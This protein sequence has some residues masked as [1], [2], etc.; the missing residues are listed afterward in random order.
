MVETPKTGVYRVVAQSDIRLSQRPGWRKNLPFKANLSTKERHN[1]LRDENAIEASD[2]A[3]QVVPE[4]A[5][6]AAREQRGVGRA[7]VLV[8]RAKNRLR[9]GRRSAGGGGG[10]CPGGGPVRWAGPCAYRRRCRAAKV[11]ARPVTGFEIKKGDDVLPHTW[12]EVLSDD[13]WE[14]YD[15]ENGYRR[16]MPDYFVPVA[17]TASCGDLD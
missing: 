10:A 15:P 3:V 12:V 2:P 17:A 9:R 5:P 4:A 16:E 8:L 14:S 6:R 13:T 1:C 11:P 7:G